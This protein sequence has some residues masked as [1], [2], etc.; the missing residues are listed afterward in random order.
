MANSISS[1]KPEVDHHFLGNHRFAFQSVQSPPNNANA[2][3]L[4]TYI[5]QVGGGEDAWRLYQAIRDLIRM[6]KN[7]RTVL[8]SYRKNED[9][10]TVPPT[11]PTEGVQPIQ[12]EWETY[13][14]VRLHLRS[15]PAISNDIQ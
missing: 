9:D 12:D 11:H 4:V 2:K 6:N 14:A 1:R 13:S 5:P 3:A 7:L 15:C 10:A 8:D